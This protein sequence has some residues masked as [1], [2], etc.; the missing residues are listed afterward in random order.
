[1]KTQG[2]AQSAAVG[3][4]CDPY[5]LL[6]EKATSLLDIQNER[7]VLATIDRILASIARTAIT[8]EDP[9]RTHGLTCSGEVM[10]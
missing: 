10:V 2:Y 6:L 7:M 5:V 9:S 3:C 1:M 4:A 8:V